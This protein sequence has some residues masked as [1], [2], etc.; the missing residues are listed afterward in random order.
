MLQPG[1]HCS[2][3]DMFLSWVSFLLS[4]KTDALEGNGSCTCGSPGLPGLK[5]IPE[6]W[7]SVGALW[8]IH[9]RK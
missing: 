5:S 4:L 2:S 3:Y 7:T 1:C 9:V 8:G 6:G